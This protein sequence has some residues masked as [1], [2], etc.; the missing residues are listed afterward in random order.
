VRV[1][2]DLL[3][4]G[5]FGG[6][7][8]VPLY[9]V[10]QA[11]TAPEKRARVVACNNILNSLFMVASALIGALFLGVAGNSIASFYLLLALMNIAVAVFIYQQVPEFTMRFLVWLL[12][13]TLYRVRHQGLEHIPER[14]AALIACNHV[15]YMDA[16]LLAGAVRRPIRFVMHQPIFEIPVL[17]FIFRVGESIPICSRSEDEAGYQAAMETIAAGLV[18]GDLLAIFPEG[19]LTAD[20]DIAE[21]R[22]GIER[23]LERTP[24]PVVPMAL[25]GLWGSFFSRC[26]GPAF[27]RPFRRFWSRVVVVAAPPLQPTEVTAAGL[28]KRILALRGADG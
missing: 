2:I 1:L 5:V 28:R 21:F 24:V 23:I 7:Y 16:L 13:H 18:Q 27:T 15:S 8:I 11:R 17:N 10:V 20:G 6:F 26:G 25:R 3:L 12:S 22:R 19:K 9:A 14:G 4:I